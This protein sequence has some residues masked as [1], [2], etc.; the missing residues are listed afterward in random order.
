MMVRNPIPSEISVWAED[1]TVIQVL[2]TNT[3]SQEF[4]NSYLGFVLTN[5][6]G[7]VVARSDLKSNFIP[8]FQ[9][10][11]MP[12]VTM[13]N[14]DRVFN[15]NAIVFDR[16]LQRLA[17]TTNSIPEGDYQMCVSVYDQYGNNITIGEE[18]CTGF[19]V[20]I[21]E[22][23]VLIAPIDDEVIVNPFPLFI[24]TPVTNYNPGRN[25]IKYKLKICPV[26]K[27]Q[28]AR[29]AIERNQV[30]FEK[31]EIF[32][33]SYQ[34]LPSDMGFDYFNGVTRYVWMVQAFDA[35]NNPASLN[36]GKS[37]LGTFLTEEEVVVETVFENVYPANGDTI[38]WAMPHLVAGLSPC[39]DQIRSLTLSL[40]VRDEASVQTFSN[41]RSLEFYY[42]PMITQVLN[43][44]EK[45]GWLTGNLDAN[46]AF[47]NWMQSLKKGKQYF[48]Q[49]AAEYTYA[50]G[51]TISRKTNET[52]FVI[53]LKKPSELKPKA[54]TSFRATH[55]IPI[56]ITIPQPD[57]LNLFTESELNNFDFHAYNS[58]STAQE[59]L[60]FELAKKESFDSLVQSKTLSL[61]AEGQLQTGNNCEALF[62]KHT[63]K[64]D[65]VA[66]TGTYFWRVKYLD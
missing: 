30:L 64:F 50:D 18:Y 16:K 40:S 5:S 38:P 36:Q 6:S 56:E 33:S 24:W 43:S 65:A 32:T 21:P 22:P 10:G 34:Y 44:E 46:K 55:E 1:P 3:A 52:A 47:P 25:Q 61:P 45:S 39:S 42:G 53:G 35:N 51:S 41:S 4:P 57:L 31:N 19:T 17:V 27:G 37:E 29:D 7:D 14:G 8:K 63:T 54:D 12:S 20:F 23:P 48:W 26:F 11:A 15:V 62:K 66:D 59:K 9:I 60:K 2:L 49:I 13:L 28:S 58:Y